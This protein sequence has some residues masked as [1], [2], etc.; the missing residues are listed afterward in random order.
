[1]FAQAYS[2]PKT[3]AFEGTLRHFAHQA[4]IAAGLKEPIDSPCAVRIVASFSPPASWSGR[5]RQAAISGELAH[6]VKP[7]LD[8]VQKAI[9]DAFNK[10]VWVDDARISKLIIEKKY[11][12]QENLLVEIW[13]RG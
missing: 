10:I 1:M 9:L 12:L 7:D 4:M 8:N 6:S 2:D 3:K 5:K 13:R 11:S